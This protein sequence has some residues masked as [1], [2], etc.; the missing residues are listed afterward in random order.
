MVLIEDAT[1]QHLFSKVGL[2]K[3]GKLCSFPKL[4]TSAPVRSGIF[5]G[6][7]ILS[8]SIFS[9]L[10]DEPSDIVSTLYYPLMK[11]KPGEVFGHFA[12]GRYW[13]DTGDLRGIWQTS[14][15]LLEHLQNSPTD[16]IR[17]CLEE[18]GEFEE[19]LPGVWTMTGIT[20]MPF[21]SNLKGPVVIGYRCSISND[22]ILGPFA[23]IGNQ[24]VVSG[25]ANLSHAIVLPLSK[26]DSQK[27]KESVCF[28]S[29]C[30]SVSADS[31]SK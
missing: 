25:G 21:A 29:Q 31:K 9:Y 23:V 6:I 27:V 16:P 12:D 13:Y 4:S 15:N 24:A 22:A 2:D 3:E 14:M 26:I 1:R 10:K 11:E 8:P 19:S 17:T 5:T 30:F 18:M 7:H 20:H 28:G